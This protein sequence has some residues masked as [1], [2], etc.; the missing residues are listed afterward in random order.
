MRSHLIH[1]LDFLRIGHAPCG[2]IGEERGAS[3]LLHGVVGLEQSGLGWPPRAAALGHPSARQSLDGKGE[4]RRLAFFAGGC[5]L[6]AAR[7]VAAPGGRGDDLA[8]SSALVDC[9]S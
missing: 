8:D 9:R 5:A 4:L 6:E 7:A 3:R 2:S 1:R